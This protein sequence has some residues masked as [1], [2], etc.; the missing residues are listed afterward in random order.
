[1]DAKAL[2]IG[3]PELYINRELSLL[4]FNRRVLAQAKDDERAAARAPEVPVHRQSSNLDE[5][6][7]IRVAGSS[8]RSAFAR[9][10]E[11]AGRMSAQEQL[12]AISARHMPWSRSQ[13]QCPERTAAA[14]AA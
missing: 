2:N 10:P 14:G 9:R 3:D 5:F 1:M 6:F 11:R 8:S 7:E 13:Y 4:E 12:R